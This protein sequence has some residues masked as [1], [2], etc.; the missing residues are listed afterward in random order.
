MISSRSNYRSA[1]TIVELLVVIV[2]IAILA[3][4]AV[5]SYNGIRDRANDAAIRS[6]L[7]NNRKKLLEYKAINGEFPPT[8][9][10]TRSEGK[11]QSGNP[12]DVSGSIYCPIASNGAFAAYHPSGVTSNTRQNFKLTIGKGLYGYTISD[13]GTITKEQCSEVSTPPAFTGYSKVYQCSSNNA[14]YSQ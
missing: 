4:M 11:C 1:F 12:G 7:V 13:D 5:V 8:F 6:D 9:T 10:Y 2:V 14:L 3:A